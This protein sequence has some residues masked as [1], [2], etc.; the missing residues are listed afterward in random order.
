MKVFNGLFFCGIIAVIVFLVRRKKKKKQQRAIEF[1]KERERQEAYKGKMIIK[2]REEFSTNGLPIL[3]ADTLQL[4]KNEVCHFI[5]DAYFCKLKQQ[6]IGYEGGSRGYSI[7]IMKGVSYR[8]G[9]HKGHY[10]R[11]ET[12]EKTGGTIYL[13]SKK[14]IFTAIK[15]SAIIKYED[16]VNVNAVDGMF[17]IQTDKKSYLFQVVDII[18]FMVTL[19]YIINKLEEHS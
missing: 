5:G 19:E 16:I 13:T 2:K 17:Q 4:T 6:T 15:N 18:T 1:A 8:I 11:Q 9:N 12:I 3:T 10:V 14:I 7:R